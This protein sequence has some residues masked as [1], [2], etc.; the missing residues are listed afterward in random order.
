MGVGKYRR[1]RTHKG[2][3]DTYK[4]FR[5]KRRPKDLDQIHEGLQKAAQV[6]PLEDENLPGLGRFACV[7]CDRHFIDQQAHA[8]HVR[9]KVHKRR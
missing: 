6:P 2:I 9:S 3:K 1:S 8:E 4:K 7:E 5:L